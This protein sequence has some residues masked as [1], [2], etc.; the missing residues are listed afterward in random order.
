MAKRMSFIHMPCTLG[1]PRRNSI[2]SSSARPSTPD[3]PRCWSAAVGVSRRRNEAPPIRAVSRPPT[4]V[5]PEVARAPTAVDGAGAVPDP[6][7]AEHPPTSRRAHSTALPGRRPL[8]LT[9]AWYAAGLS[10]RSTG[11]VVHRPV[12]SS[13][14]ATSNRTERHR[15][16]RH[17]TERHRTIVPS[18]GLRLDALRVKPGWRLRLRGRRSERDPA[19]G[20]PGGPADDLARWAWLPRPAGSSPAPTGA[21]RARDG[22][23]SGGRHPPRWSSD[24]CRP[25]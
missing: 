23:T 16:E 15:T 24:G 4:S 3:S 13:E 12:R 17:R 18:R 7:A 11:A 5:V 9:P 22:A 6:A 19:G 8:G 14:S 21:R 2:P 20:F 25:P 1:P 10:G